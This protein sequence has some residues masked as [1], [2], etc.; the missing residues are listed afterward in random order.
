MDDEILPRSLKI[1][2][3][4]FRSF[5]TFL[6]TSV[7]TTPHYSVHSLCNPTHTITSI[8][9]RPKAYICS[10][11]GGKSATSGVHT[12][13]VLHSYFTCTSL[14]LHSYFTRTSLVLHTT[15][16]VLQICFFEIGELSLFSFGLL[17]KMK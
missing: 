10:I 15:S 17:P 8:A 16:L 9:F 4:A 3:L 2:R 6:P 12:S 7:Y 11:Q 13:F 14:V 1:L 5:D